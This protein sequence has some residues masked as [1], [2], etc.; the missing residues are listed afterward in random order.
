[1]GRVAII[2][3]SLGGFEAQSK[4]EVKIK[5]IDLILPVSSNP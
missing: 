5:Y 1:M 4:K 2:A 3:Y